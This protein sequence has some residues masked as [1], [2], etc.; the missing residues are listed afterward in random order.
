M[1]LDLAGVGDMAHIGTNR[2]INSL[3]NDKIQILWEKALK[4][5]KIC[6]NALL[7]DKARVL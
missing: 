1:V 2:Y 3:L 6:K 7:F 4:N 5:P